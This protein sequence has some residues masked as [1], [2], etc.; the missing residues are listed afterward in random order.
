MNYKLGSEAFLAL[1]TVLDGTPLHMDGWAL[2]QALEK[3]DFEEAHIVF[4]QAQ[5]LET[6]SSK[7]KTKM[8]TS[9]ALWVPMPDGGQA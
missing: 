7:A 4:V 9:K 1:W 2:E 3:G 5:L 6:L 8:S